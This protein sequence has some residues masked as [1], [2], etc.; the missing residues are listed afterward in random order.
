MIVNNRQLLP[1]EPAKSDDPKVKQVDRDFETR[2]LQLKKA[3]R[4]FESFFYLHVLKA[5]RSTIPK[6]DF[7]KDG[8]G[9]EVY[10]SMFDMEL[11]K[12]MSGSSANSLSELLYRSLEKHIASASSQPAEDYRLPEQNTPNFRD[13]GTT[14]KTDPVLSNYGSMIDEISR[15]YN[16]NPRLI[17]SVIMAE[18]GGDFQAISPRGA[19]GLMQLMDSTA[20]EM[21]VSDTLN[22]RQ[23]I[24]GG[25][26]YLRRLL[27][28]YDG[29]L[30]LALA[31][32]N[33]GPGVVSKYNGVPP[34]SETRRY[35]VKIMETLYR[36]QH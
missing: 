27:D 25:A 2:K 31:A 22:P 18:S 28:K 35:I 29:D 33:A 20:V 24:E 3:T 1:I 6:S 13:T 36:S 5:M 12:K 19:K 17:Y 34:Y 14:I 10:N 26:K 7:L 30:K 23:N 4:D 9:G 21:G 32:Y 16:L 11:A 15:K 8:L